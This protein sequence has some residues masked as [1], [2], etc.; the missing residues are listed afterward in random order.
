M[1]NVR[2][3]FVALLLGV[4]ALRSSGPASAGVPPGR[5]A[6]GDSV[7]LGAKDELTGRGFK[8]NAVVSRQ[9]RDAVPLV[10]RLKAA[11]RLRRKVIIHLGNN[12]ILI[13]AA[14]CDRIAEIAGP[15]RTVYLVNL[16][17]PRS[18]RRIQNERLAACAQRRANTLLIDWFHYSR[19]HPSWFAAD[20]YHLT[21]AGQ[22]KFAALIAM[23]TA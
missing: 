23:K 15:G 18:Y 8:V 5:Y 7:M 1:P 22:T 10:Q 20:G 21:S 14:D 17:I 9:F 4:L 11:G 2:R 16:K 6:I 12:G 13:A 3:L 19:N